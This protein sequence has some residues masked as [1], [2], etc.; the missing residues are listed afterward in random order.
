MDDA[1]LEALATGP[2]TSHTLVRLNLNECDVGDD[3]LEELVACCPS[4]AFVS[5]VGCPRVT[6]QRAL[7]LAHLAHVQIVM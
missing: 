4:L 2:G 1:A 6:Y 7:R 5:V 3:A